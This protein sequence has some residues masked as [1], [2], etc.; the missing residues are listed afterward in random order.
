LTG[1]EDLIIKLAG[2]N[3]DNLSFNSDFGTVALI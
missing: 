1:G 2:V 3:G